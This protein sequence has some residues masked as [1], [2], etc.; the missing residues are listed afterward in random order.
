VDE[1]AAETGIETGEVVTSM[2][3][4]AEPTT[5]SHLTDTQKDL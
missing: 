4:W 1:V 2:L 5:I 3:A